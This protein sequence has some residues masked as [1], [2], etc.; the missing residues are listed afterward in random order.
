M[1][2]L[3]MCLLVLLYTLQLTAQSKETIIAF[4]SCDDEDEPQEMWKEVIAQ[5]PIVWIWGGDNVYA[6]THDMNV[7]KAKYDKQKSNPD[8]QKLMRMCTITGTWDDHD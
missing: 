1:K 8:Y 4:G 6:D 5:K 2:S 7:L 3:S